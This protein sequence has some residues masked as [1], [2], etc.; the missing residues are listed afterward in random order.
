MRTGDRYD[1]QNEGHVHVHGLILEYFL[2]LIIHVIEHVSTHKCSHD[3]KRGVPLSSLRA[4]ESRQDVVYLCASH[5][6]LLLG[7]HQEKACALVREHA[8]YNNKLL[9]YWP[10]P[11]IFLS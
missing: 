5:S 10:S 2:I 1:I 3:D 7:I 6:C 9:S 11:R 8:Y 4:P